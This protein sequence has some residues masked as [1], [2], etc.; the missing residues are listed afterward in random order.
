MPAIFYYLLKLSISLSVVFLFYQLVLRKLTFYN[1]NRWYLLGYTLLSFFIP[2]IN[3]SPVLEKNEWSTNTLVNWVPVIRGTSQNNGSGNQFSLDKWEI[4]LLV[5]VTGMLFML[6]RLAVQF[7]SFRRMKQKAV[8][9]S[10]GD[11]KLY[12]VDADIIPFSFGNSIFINQHLH[13]E[14]ELQE[15]IRHEFVHVKQKHSL[16]ILW[17]ELLLLLNWYNPFCW[18]LKKAIRQNLEFV[19]DNQVLQHGVNKKD[20]QYLLLKVIGNSQYSIANQF[21]FSSLKKRIAMMNKM[22]SA[23]RQLL[24][25]L[26]LLP[27]TAI[28]LLA[29]RNR[30]NDKTSVTHSPA[31]YEK[32]V[33]VAGLVVDAKTLQPIAGVSIFCKRAN[34]TVVTDERGYYKL[35]VPFGNEEL[36]FDMELSKTGYA[37]FHQSEHWGNFNIDGI[38]AAFGHT[39]ELFA[40]SKNGKDGYSTI[41]GNAS[42]E[43]G[44]SYERVASRL[45]QIRNEIN[46]VYQPNDTVP[47]PPPPPPPP[48]AAVKLPDGVVSINVQNQK[49]TVKLKNGKKEYYNLDVPSEKEAFMKKYPVPPPPPEPVQLKLSDPQSTEPAAD[50]FAP[51]TAAGSSASSDRN[52]PARVVNVR[53]VSRSTTAPVAV[54]ISSDAVSDDSRAAARPA[55]PR[56]SENDLPVAT[57][58]A[59]SPLYVING[60]IATKVEV[61]RI[62]PNSITTVNVLKGANATDKYGSK[63]Q[64]GVV[65]VITRENVPHVSDVRIEKAES[66]TR[67]NNAVSVTSSSISL[68]NSNQLVMLDGKEVP[69]T[70]KPRSFSGTYKLVTLTKEEAV[71]KYGEKG[72]NGAV[73]MTTIK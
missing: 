61:D 49:A 54:N 15:I 48:P 71:K 4:L 11:L 7:V 31:R 46:G 50:S 14:Q 34:T 10:N 16:D 12:Q 72:K 62:N 38:Y 20:Y 37:G 55:A 44:L 28:L 3:I 13:T 23:Q 9:L 36:L 29:F 1:W 40:L 60:D 41:A 27:A 33:V 64:D 22:K 58:I 57:S 66:V 73:E 8:Q 47:P 32:K 18:L 30:H 2:F 56:S 52:A 26:F 19:A 45:P 69:N 42:N 6:V 59:S 5:L 24:R 43:S 51:A 65:E 17:S 21:N 67:D 70:G 63:G 39:I 25:M 35:Y 53:N 68:G